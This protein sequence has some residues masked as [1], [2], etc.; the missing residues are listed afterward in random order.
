MTGY[1]YPATDD[2]DRRQGNE[3]ERL[4]REAHQAHEVRQQLQHQYYEAVR[5]E[6]IA[7]AAYSD[8]M[9]GEQ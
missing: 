9:P 7:D 2:V 1:R 6:I 8:A 3:I 5:A 4:R